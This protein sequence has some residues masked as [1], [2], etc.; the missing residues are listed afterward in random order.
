MAIPTT[1]PRWRARIR[2]RTDFMKPHK[3]KAVYLS[4]YT[5][6]NE[7]RESI[8][9]FLN[10]VYNRERLHSRLGY[11]PPEE[12]EAKLNGPKPLTIR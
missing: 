5:N 12:F 8:A 6:L 9:R 4:D 11:V 1:T 7:A 2:V 10:Q 3:Y